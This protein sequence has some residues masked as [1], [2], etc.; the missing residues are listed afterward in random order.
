MS[1]TDID[2]MRRRLKPFNKVI[3]AL[4]RAGLALGTMRVLSVPGRKSGELRTTP[5]SPLTVDGI[6]YVV[7]GFEQADWV[8]NARA[9]GWGELARGRRRHRVILTELPVEERAPILRAF[10]REVP[11]GVQFFV[12]T[13][14]ITSP[15]PDSF[16]AAAPRC[17]V[18]RIDRAPEE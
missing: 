9:A 6:T 11:H 4:Q 5:V 18:F 1:N 13:G 12:K 17:P 16:A 10:P 3:V 8:K 2:R 7:G 14:V 15:D